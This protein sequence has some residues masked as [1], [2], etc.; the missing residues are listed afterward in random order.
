MELLGVS[1]LARLHVLI[2]RQVGVGVKVRDPLL[3]L[4]FHHRRFNLCF[5][6]ANDFVDGVTS[7]QSLLAPVGKSRQDANIIV[8][9]RAHIQVQVQQLEIL[10]IPWTSTRTSKRQA[11]YTDSRR[12][13]ESNLSRYT[14]S[15]TRSSHRAQT[16]ILFPY[17]TLSLSLR[18]ALTSLHRQTTRKTWLGDQRFAI[19]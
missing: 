1:H 6:L 13:G 9:M 16:H 18:T 17:S 5:L 7:L 8:G 10:S 3:H 2:V 12:G 4:H 15:P 19:G 14:P 11:R